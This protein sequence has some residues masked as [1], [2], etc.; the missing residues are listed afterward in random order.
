MPSSVA[1][2]ICTSAPGSAILRT[3]SRSSSEK[4]RPTPNISSITPISASCAAMLDIG[5]EA[6]REGA[7][8]H[9]RQQVADQRRQPQPRREEAEHQRQAEAGGDGVDQ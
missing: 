7:D 4:C 9:A 5:D 6:R 3:A 1:T 2:A 8:D